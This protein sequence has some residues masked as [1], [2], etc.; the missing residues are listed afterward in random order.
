MADA[1]ISALPSAT[2][3]LAGTEVL[4]IV[5]S[6]TTDKVT[7]AD[8]LRQN[9]QT[10]TTSNPVL[11]LAQTWNAGGVTFTGMQ[12]AITDTASAAPSLLLDLKVGGVSV[13]S[14]GKTGGFSTVASSMGIYNNSAAIYMG[15]SGDV[16]LARDAANTLALRNGTNAQTFNVYSTYTDASNNEGLKI[17]A[18][19]SSVDLVA[20]SIGTGGTRPLRFGINDNAQ[21]QINT[22][23]HFTAAA[24]NI[25]DIGASGAT[26]PRTIYTG[27]QFIGPDGSASAP[28]FAT[29]VVNTGM[30]RDSGGGRLRFTVGGTYTGIN[31]GA[32]VIG[33][34]SDTAQI[35]LGSGQDTILVRDAA[36]T[37][38]L[39]N[40][41]N[42][43]SFK[44]Y[45]TYTDASNYER[46]AINAQSGADVRLQTEKA[47]TGTVRSIVFGTNASGRWYIDGASGHFLAATDA[48]YDIGQSG[49]TRPRNIYASNAFVAGGGIDA[50]S[51]MYIYTGTAIPAGGTTGAG[52]RM[53]ST[54]NFGVF[55]GSGAPTLSAA[56]GSLY[57]RSDGSGT[58][59]RM[60]VN[61]DGSTAWTAVTTAT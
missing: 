31:F 11:S 1:K 25:Y 5:Q 61:T 51:R 19:T 33:I 20:R 30:Y 24:D 39:R 4:P 15:G 17:R 56:K 18:L 50:I 49:A 8:L 48:T 3:P 14:V 16:V 40:S 7:A 22:N 45:N 2:V 27:T 43:Q 53:S 42:A 29:G 26:R 38:A 34:S 46:F 41:T 52:Y 54:S 59:D 6:G 35:E 58:G 23:G 36:N 44:V 57:L 13:F 60:Y 21:W 37:V 47:G 55:F 10:V 32:S 28:T 12:L 9:G